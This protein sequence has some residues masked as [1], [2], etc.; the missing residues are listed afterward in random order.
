MK[1]TAK[2]IAEFLNGKVEGNEDVEVNNVSK[3]E[4]GK[5]GTLSFLA[6][7]KYNQF[8]YLT[9][10]SI[11]IVNNDFVAEKEIQS[12]LIRVEDSYKAFASL[13]ELYENATKKNEVGISE[14]SYIEKTASIAEGVYIEPFV[15]VGKNVKIEK[16]V[17]VHANTY[18]GDNVIIDENTILNS[19]VN[20]YKNSIIGKN[21]IIHSGV[22][23]GSDGF[24]FAPQENAEFKKIPQAGNVIV[25]DNV[26]IGANTTIDRATMGSTVLGKGVKLDNLIQIAHN[27]E[28]GDN[29]VMAAQVGIAGS[30]KVGKNCMFGG[31]A[32]IAGH[33]KIADNVKIGAKSGVGASVKD[34][35][36][37]I[38]G[39]P[40][41]GM[42]NFYRSS[43][44][45]KILP[46]IKR[47]V[48]SLTKKI[49]K[50]T[51]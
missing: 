6:N 49:E 2:A 46:D 21:C 23:I 24:G 5:K 8:I 37:I 48:D 47:E 34:E 13:L 29:T 30:T 51:E 26:E 36:A 15:Y 50:L 45:F 27:V 31:Q 33:L 42:R 7:P 12:T 9:D 1:F 22:V 38:Q 11:V 40:A 43:A 28:I 17:R 4:E 39:V 44:V 32:A 3:I 10:A 19:N 20:I 35:G 14:K 18:I 25:N 16:N 41:I